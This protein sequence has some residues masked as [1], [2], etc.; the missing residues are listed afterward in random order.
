MGVKYYFT[1]GRVALFHGL[2]S[3]NLKKKD[4]ILLPEIICKE[5]IIPFKKL[6][7]KYKFYNL[8]KNLTPD[9]SNIKTLNNAKV[10]GI[11]MVHYFGFPNDIKKFD[12]FRKNN[13]KLL[14]EDYC[15]GLDGKY[16][17]FTLG[18]I[19]DISVMSPR[20][21]IKIPSGGILK[22]NN[23]NLKIKEELSKLKKKKIN[24]SQIIFFLLKNSLIIIKIKRFLKNFLKIKLYSKKQSLLFENQIIDKF[25]LNVLKKKSYNH[26]E[27]IEK[28]KWIYKIL[29]KN[30]CEP[31]F[32]IKKNV[33]PWQVPFYLDKKN[34]NKKRLN[35]I[36]LKHNF[37]I[38]KWPSVFL[39][40]NKTTKNKLKYNPIYCVIID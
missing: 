27:R 38:I 25:S 32:E 8:N 10:K 28:Y 20:K 33:V 30:S 18:N 3:L 16:Q 13:N 17:N 4:I 11:M 26:F 39:K 1:S 14:I 2:K 35:K 23:S 7:I 21:I 36:M 34:C 24:F 19:G 15:H 12:S 37:N 22:L 6:N 31:I 5:A 9:W 40:I 29:I